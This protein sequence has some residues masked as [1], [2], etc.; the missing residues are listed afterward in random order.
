MSLPPVVPPVSRWQL[1]FSCSLS[2]P[3]GFLSLPGTHRSFA[4]SPLWSPSNYLLFSIN[5]ILTHF[6]STLVN[7]AVIASNLVKNSLSLLPQLGHDFLSWGGTYHGCGFSYLPAVPAIFESMNV[8]K[9]KL[10]EKLVV[11]FVRKTLFFFNRCLC[12][13]WIR[14]ELNY[15]LFTEWSARWRPAVY[16]CSC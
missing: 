6:T 7:M 10:E 8:G 11:K 14:L 15:F 1:L 2:A 13:D 4:Q 12:D 16:K 9:P 5:N 3:L